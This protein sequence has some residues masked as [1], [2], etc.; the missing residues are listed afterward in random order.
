MSELNEAQKLAQE[1]YFAGRKQ[2][3]RPQAML[4]S[5]NPGFIVNGKRLPEGDEFD[6]FIILSDDNRAPIQINN[7]RIERRDRMVNGRMRSY[8]IADKLRFSTDWSNLPS[9]AFNVIPEFETIFSDNTEQEFLTGKVTNLVTS[10]DV[11]GTERPVRSSGSPFFKDQQFTSD[12]GAGGADMLEWYKNNQGSFWL[13]LSY[14][15]HYNLNN[16]RNRLK[17]Y[18]EVVEVFF[19]LFDYTVEKRGGNN[20]DYWNISMT[21]DEV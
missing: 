20:H 8:H 21:L 10:V 5:N 12:A 14:D 9:R 19:E 16:E 1:A 13:F 6:D 4:F 18:S 2:Y 15:N 17:E 11:E 7:Q 3:A